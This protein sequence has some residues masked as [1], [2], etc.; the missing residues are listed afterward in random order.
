MS[1]L[2]TIVPGD[3]GTV[4]LP[5]IE[6]DYRVSVAA[7]MRVLLG[8]LLRVDGSLEQKP[9]AKGAD[10]CWYLDRRLTGNLRLKFPI[11]HDCAKES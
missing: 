3:V 1:K 2:N 4:E 10:F 9:L 5:R 8:E 7:E 6:E 11:V